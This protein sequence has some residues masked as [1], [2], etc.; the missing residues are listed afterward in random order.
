V[1]GNRLNRSGLYWCLIESDGRLGV[2][3]SMTRSAALT[4]T[5]ATSGPA[6]ALSTNQGSIYVPPVPPPPPPNSCCG[7]CGYI[8]YNNGGSGFFR[9]AGQTLTIQLSLS[10]SMSP[11]IN[12]ANY[13]ARWRYGGGTNQ[14]GCFQ[15]ISSTQEQFTAPVTAP[16][17]ITVY[18]K[19]GCPP[20][21][22]SY[23]M[24]VQ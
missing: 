18:I 19:S 2:L 17:T 21:G 6:T 9:S 3:Q 11:L 7:Y 10:P 14:T 8:N 16:Y 12:T 20:N 1:P 5:F 13:C 15:V 22:T 24:T 23:Y 4:E